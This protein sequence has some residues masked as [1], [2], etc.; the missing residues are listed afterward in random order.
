MKSAT[1]GVT[2]TVKDGWVVFGFLVLWVNF[3]FFSSQ[4]LFY[5]RTHT[6]YLLRSSQAPTNQ[7][8]PVC[9]VRF[10][11]VILFKGHIFHRD[12]PFDFLQC[13]IFPWLTNNIMI[14]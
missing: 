5:T 4:L 6:I 10:S 12:F 13:A 9:P 7:S 14:V 1:L 11:I 2:I 3:L 8:Q